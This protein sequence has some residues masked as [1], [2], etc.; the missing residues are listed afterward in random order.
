M[1]FEVSLYTYTSNKYAYVEVHFHNVECLIIHKGI[2]PI[3]CLLLPTEIK[4][5]YVLTSIETQFELSK[6]I[7]IKQPS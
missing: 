1:G 4:F 5:K 6:Y 2:L 7:R 3:C